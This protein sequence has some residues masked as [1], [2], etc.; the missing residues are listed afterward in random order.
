M[1][2]K[3][4]PKSPKMLKEVIEA[5]M[6]NIDDIPRDM[7][8]YFNPTAW[9]LFSPGDEKVI[10]DIL[11]T[12]ED[13]LMQED[14]SYIDMETFISD[15]APEGWYLWRRTE[16][17]KDEWLIWLSLEKVRNGEW[18]SMDFM[19]ITPSP[20]EG[21]PTNPFLLYWPDM[22]QNVFQNDSW[23]HQDDFLYTL[24]LPTDE[25]KMWVH[26]LKLDNIALNWKRFPKV[27]VEGA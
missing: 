11:R 22:V 24:V 2:R 21:P 26:V 12:M 19:K 20:G 18:D 13:N 23:G 8:S 25:N 4:T 16:G 6:L 14:P 15:S 17:Q 5:G 7:D 1:A 3:K 9:R 27:L 10:P